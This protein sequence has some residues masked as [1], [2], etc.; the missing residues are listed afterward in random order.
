MAQTFH[1]GAQVVA[2]LKAQDPVKIGSGEF[3]FACMY[4][5][6]WLL[7]SQT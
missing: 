2:A 4:V 7:S 5:H 3:T 6:S 1:S